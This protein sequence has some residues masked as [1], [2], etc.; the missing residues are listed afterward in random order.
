MTYLQALKYLESFINYEKITSYPYKESLKLER[1]KN[2]LEILGNPQDYLKCIHI[3]GTKGK[4]S[5]CAFIAY[6]LREAGYRVG[7]YTSPHLSDFRERIRILNHPADAPGRHRPGKEFEGM[8]LKKE[9]AGLIERLKPLIERYNRKSAFGALSFFEVYTSLAFIYFREKKVDIAVLETGLGGRLDATNVIEPLV[10][11]ITPISY[12][13]TQK[14]GNALKEIATEKAGIIKNHQ[15]PAT[16]HQPI[17]IT[18]M[19]EKEAIEV[20]RKKCKEVDAKLFEMGR[21]IQYETNGG[22]DLKIKGIFGE[23]QN[24]RLRLLGQHQLVNATLAV[25]AIEALRFCNINVGIGAIKKGLYN[26]IWPGRCEIV[27]KKPLVILDGAQNTA[28]AKALK[29]TIR[30]KFR[31]KKLILVLGIS[32]DKDI[33][34]ICSEFYD[35][36]DE[37]ILTKANNPRA[38]EPESLA[39]YFSGKNAYLTTNIKEAIKLAKQKAKEKDLVLITGSLF[40]VGEAR[41]LWK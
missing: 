23:Y 26:T 27:S 37:V 41:E 16:S 8:I 28:S 7:L 34:G 19:Q 2:F 5:T 9:L 38:T 10:C 17:V 15:P 24:L 30:D 29:E 18:A 14:L 4:G 1:I 21:Q 35:L 32:K 22:K 33:K 20:I 39:E 25:S 31:Y 6:I 12:E 13:H 11:A 40:V 3:A 36:T